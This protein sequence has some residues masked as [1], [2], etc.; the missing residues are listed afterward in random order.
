MATVGER[1]RE[2]REARGWTQEKLAD[3]AQISK[4]FLSEVENRGK[5]LSLGVLLRIAT[6][7]G[8]S[9]EYLATG[10]GE[11]A[12]E[13]EPVVIPRELAKAAEELHLSYK[14]TVQLLDAYNSVVAR[15]SDRGRREFTAQDW[16]DLHRA[17]KTVIRKVY[18]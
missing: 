9:V 11:E 7:I 13:R 5:N 6:A 17:I 12:R 10:E 3:A 15:R 14:D 4:G 2:V 16:K 1:I 8:A 18:G